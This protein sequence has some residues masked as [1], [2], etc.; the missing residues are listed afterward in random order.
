MEE[1]KDLHEAIMELY[2][3]VKIRHTDEVGRA[4]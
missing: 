3:N 2:L 4:G 1:N